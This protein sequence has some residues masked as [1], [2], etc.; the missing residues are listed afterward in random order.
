MTLLD[1]I[2]YLAA[3]CSIGV[4]LICLYENDTKLGVFCI[5]MGMIAAV[6]N[7]IL[8]IFL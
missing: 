7:F 2:C 3:V 1:V 6:G 5:S 8:G 4:G